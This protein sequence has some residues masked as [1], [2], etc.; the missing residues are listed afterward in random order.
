MKKTLK[1]VLAAGS[2]AFL[3]AGGAAVAATV[4]ISDDYNVTTD[5]TGFTL[6]TG[7]NFGI[8]PPWATRLTGN[9]AAGLRYVQTGA[10]KAASAHQ[11]YNNQLRVATD[12]NS[13]HFALSRN[14]ATSY[15][16]GEAMNIAAATPANPAIYQL[17]IKLR[18]NATSTA[19]FSFAI[20]TA[21]AVANDW[22]F[23]IQM[24]RANP[25][26][27][28][29]QIQRRINAASS[30][31][32]AN[33]NAVLGTTAPGTVGT[34]CGF[35]IEITDAGAETTTYSSRARVSF[36]DGAT[37]VYDTSADTGNMPAGWRF[38]GPGRFIIF[39]QA[40]NNSGAVFYDDFSLTWISGPPLPEP[41]LA[42]VWS[43]NGLNNNWSDGANWNGLAPTNTDALVFRGTQR[44]VNTNDLDGLTVPLVA[45]ENGGFSL[46]GNVFTNTGAVSNG[47]G[48][49]FLGAEMAWGLTGGKFWSVMSGSELI[50][51]N[52][53]SAETVGDHILAG[54]GLLRQTGTYGIGQATTANPPFLVNE[55]THLINGG[56]FISRGGYR[57]GSQPTGGGA[58]LILTNQAAFT[59]TASGANLRVGDSA[60]PSPAR[61][62][63][64]RSSLALSGGVLGI[65]YSAG[66][67]GEVTQVGGLVSGAVVS[68]NHSGAAK[69]AYLLSD[70]AVLDPVLIRKNNANGMA[71]IYFDNAILRSS[72]G[73]SNAFFAGLDT[74]E[75]RSGGLVL[76][77]AVDIV[78]G[79]NLSGAG[80]LVKSNYA[81]ATL[82][83][84][85]HY[86]GATAVRG[87]KLTLGVGGLYGTVQV[88]DFCELGVLA[89]APGLSVTS[90]VVT[91]GN[92]TLSFDLGTLGNPTQPLLRCGTLAPQGTVFINIANGLALRTGRIV[93]V[94]YDTLG[95]RGYGAL[96]LN[97]LPLG[98]SASLAN[99]AQ[100][101][102]IDL[103]IIATPGYR[104]TGAVDEN[105]DSFTQNWISQQT[106]SPAAYSDG[107]PTEFPDQA[108]RKD[109]TVETYLFPQP[110]ILTVSNSAG[111]YRLTGGIIT[112]PTLRK[113]G[114]SALVRAGGEADEIGTLELNE[115]SVVLSNQFDMTLTA[116]LTDDG[117][118]L[119]AF[120][121]AGLNQMTVNSA[122]NGFNGAILVQEG[123]FRMGHNQSLGATNGGT[124]VANGATLDIR[125]FVAVG[126]PVTVSGFGMDGRGAITASGTDSTVQN[127]LTDVT[128]AGDTAFGCDAAGARWDL[129]VRSA[130]GPGPGLRGNGYNLSKVGPGFVSI[131]CVR[132]MGEQTPYWQMNL[133]DINVRQG[134]LTLAEAVTPGNP[135]KRI[136]IWDGAILGTF[137][138][139]LSNPIVRGIFMTNAT[140][141]SGGTATSSNVFNG[142]IHLEGANSLQ[143]DKDAAIIVNGAISG[144]GSLTISAS[145]S[146]RVFLNGLNT[147][148][149]GTTLSGGAL[150]GTGSIQGN[151]TVTTGTLSPGVDGVGTLTIGGDLVVPEGATT[152]LE[153]NRNLSPNSDRIVV[154][155]S[156]SFGGTLRVS[157]LANPR[158][159]DIYRLFGKG[160]GLAFSSTVLPSLAALPGNLSWD[161]SALATEGTL[162]V[163]GVAQ[164]A[165]I[166]SVTF[167]AGQLEIHGTGGVEGMPY[168][169]VTA[170]EVS[171]PLASWT[172]VGRTNLFGPG[173]SFSFTNTPGMHPQAFFRLVAPQ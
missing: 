64:D 164:P 115:G 155:G 166:S 31:G 82:A 150:G 108:V 70:G 54:G 58:R 100:N 3:L 117:A 131:A 47:A 10:G 146:S 26:D 165:S 48:I 74:A 65:G 78:I 93:L 59:L 97:N 23:G 139:G 124:T 62:I 32:G 109:I 56:A 51:P 112:T 63:I 130:S 66:S 14:G 13:G 143:P 46:H 162:K 68:F 118:G 160:G 90:S 103:I 44:Q 1:L 22:D 102:S 94:D 142:P 123:V 113:R 41:G 98:V 128:L 111:D 140:I 83:G 114:T 129:R 25:A 27:T 30:S 106:G 169:F 104:W 87:G 138:L 171:T 60:H 133:G 159:G 168:F 105:W 28:F 5:T 153:L 145:G 88:D 20:A 79:Q 173:G 29:Y 35:L 134:T 132:N 125:N 40:A 6:N 16:F 80:S 119:G 49:N 137:D 92:S 42:K 110:A 141:L 147:H 24:Y 151:L 77:P 170:M 53:V 136:A 167:T 75:I 61:L 9:A 57:V 71:E 39:D 37:W 52:L 33:L 21:D 157:L 154:G 36:D 50:I 72:F 144:P 85:N 76:D 19:R 43:G 95:G 73:A 126:E 158:A 122:N 127:N 107:L 4:I 7:I 11:I 55:G 18:N 38:D 84:A 67:T 172:P 15:D 161:T 86:G 152:V 163:N 116:V 34:L 45:F 121:K 148:Q 17:R 8:N 89:Q 91:L 96:A 135:A 101:G 12:G 2:L 120:V 99:N 149:G 156:Q 81:G 69:G